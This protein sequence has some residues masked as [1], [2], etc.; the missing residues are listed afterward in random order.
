MPR[1]RLGVAVMTVLTTGKDTRRAV[2]CS[3]GFARICASLKAANIVA[4][5]H[6]AEGCE[7]CDHTIQIIEPDKE[8]P[9]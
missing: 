2:Y 8:A 6:V 4:A 1:L 9:R 7:G 3:C 5:I